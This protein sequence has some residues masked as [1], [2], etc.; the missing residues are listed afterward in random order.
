MIVEY[1]G[2]LTNP[3]VIGSILVDVVLILCVIGIA[4]LMLL[5]LFGPNASPRKR[6]VALVLAPATPVRAQAGAL[7]H[8][9]EYP[10]AGGATR[11]PPSVPPMQQ[12]CA[13]SMVSPSPAGALAPADRVGTNDL[14]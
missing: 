5:A 13:S 8:P 7:L 14:C 12:A 4:M 2:V 9:W 10:C 11:A 1:L 6:A 3:E